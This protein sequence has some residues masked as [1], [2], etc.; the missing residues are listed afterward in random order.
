MLPLIGGKDWPVASIFR[1]RIEGKFVCLC[2]DIRQS[3]SIA[4]LRLAASEQ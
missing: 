1:I 4:N 2:E 3:C